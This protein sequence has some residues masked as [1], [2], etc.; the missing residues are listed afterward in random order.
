MMF[1]VIDKKWG[2]ANNIK[3]KDFTIAGKTGTCQ[4]DY[5][6]DRKRGPI[7]FKFRWLFSC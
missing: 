7:Y 2:T 1:N 3:D 6:R 5:N 4:V